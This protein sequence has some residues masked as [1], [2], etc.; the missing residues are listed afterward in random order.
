MES[1]CTYIKT[2]DRWRNQEEEETEEGKEKEED[3]EVG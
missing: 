2:A 3:T 1:I